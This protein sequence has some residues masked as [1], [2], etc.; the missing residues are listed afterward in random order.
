M[1]APVGRRKTSGGL[2][3]TWEF[4]S[5]TR[6]DKSP[7]PS[8]Y[9][10]FLPSFLW[11]RTESD[12]SIIH[13]ITRCISFNKLFVRLN[14]SARIDAPL[15]IR[16]LAML[17]LFRMNRDM[18]LISWPHN[19]LWL[20]RTMKPYMIWWI[21]FH[22]LLFREDDLNFLHAECFDRTYACQP[23]G[24]QRIHYSTL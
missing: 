13:V 3:N 6:R 8:Y 22:S 15:L 12:R 20:P 1:T 16:R 17:N 5:L 11:S 2:D 4:F 9:G 18:S 19:M 21:F 14:L 10:N 23:I 24:L 7:C